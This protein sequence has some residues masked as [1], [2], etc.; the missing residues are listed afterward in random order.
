MVNR[1]SKSLNCGELGGGSQSP[2]ARQA[3]RC[4]EAERKRA[5]LSGSVEAPWI[6]EHMDSL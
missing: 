3:A 6:P 4:R 5:T 1:R 2:A